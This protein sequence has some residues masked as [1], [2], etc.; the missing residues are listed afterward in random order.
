MDRLESSFQAEN[1]LLCIVAVLHD[2]VEIHPL[3]DLIFS[4]QYLV[5]TGSFV[6]K[7]LALQ[8]DSSHKRVLGVQRGV[9][10]LPFL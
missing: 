4:L 3:D 2:N 8:T 6:T 7:P 5:E 1:A 9:K 10:L